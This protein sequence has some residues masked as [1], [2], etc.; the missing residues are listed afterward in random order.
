MSEQV[1]WEQIL[2]SEG[3]GDLDTQIQEGGHLPRQFELGDVALAHEVDPGEIRQ[4]QADIAGELE[5]P[6]VDVDRFLRDQ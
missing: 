5:G 2:A 3:L 6:E 4:A 1:D